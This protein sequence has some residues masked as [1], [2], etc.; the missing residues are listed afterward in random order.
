MHINVLS[1]ITYA[2]KEEEKK[3]N[4]LTRFKH[5]GGSKEEEREGKT[6]RG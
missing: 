6:M 5:G 2:T 3:E 4:D 1:Q